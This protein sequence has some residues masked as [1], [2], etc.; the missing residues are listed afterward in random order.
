MY[1]L[2]LQVHV[3][4]QVKS[5]RIGQAYLHTCLL[6]YSLHVVH[7]EVVVPQIL[8]DFLVGIPV[9]C[10]LFHQA[11]KEIFLVRIVH[12]RGILCLCHNPCLFNCFLQT[13]K[14]VHKTY[15]L[16][17]YACPHTTFSNSLDAVL[18]HL[19][20]VSTT[21]CEEFVASIHIL[22]GY[23][24]LLFCEGTREVAK[25]AESICLHGAEVYTQLVIQEFAC[26][27]EHAKD[28]DR[29]S[30]GC[31]FCKDIVSRTT[32]IVAT[33]SRHVAHAHHN[34][35]IG[36]DVHHLMPNLFAG[37][38]RT[39]TRVHTEHYGSHLVIVGQFLQVFTHSLA[40]DL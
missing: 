21:L 9:T 22:M 33:R 37:V 36:L 3:V 6:L 38:G 5:E 7:N 10:H 14:F 31:G 15:L 17:M 30:D 1:Y 24:V 39:A 40:N 20:S 28:A 19:S 29:A 25:V 16:C 26:I 2:F 35:L 8:F 27:R 32:D 11:C 12:H 23:C 18:L 4:L 13:A 34:G